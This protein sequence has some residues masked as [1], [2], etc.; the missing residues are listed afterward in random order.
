MC[1][2]SPALGRTILDDQRQALSERR[3]RLLK[4]LAEVEVA[5][6]RAGGSIAGTAHCGTLP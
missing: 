3:N 1:E 2:A 5:L 6:S 4:E